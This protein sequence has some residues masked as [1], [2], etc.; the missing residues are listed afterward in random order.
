MRRAV[1]QLAW[2]SRSTIPALTD[3]SAR[4]KRT[5]LIGGNSPIDLA[6]SIA[7]TMAIPMHD[8]ENEFDEEDWGEDYGTDSDAEVDTVP[9]PECGAEVYEEAEACPACGYFMLPADRLGKNAGWWTF[10]GAISHWPPLLIALALLGSLATV[11]I[12]I[13]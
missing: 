12:L 10:R 5:P 13:F 8:D 1:S 11:L 2:Q 4:S 7:E 9:C 6:I 3:Q